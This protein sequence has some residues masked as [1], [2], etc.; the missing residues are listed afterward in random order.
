[1]SGALAEVA[2]ERARQDARWGEQN[3]PDGTGAVLHFEDADSARLVCQTRAR[4]GEVTWQHIL[5]EEYCEAMQED[6]PARLR[7]ELL[8][9]AAV[10]VN[11]IEAI[12]RR[13]VDAEDVLDGP[14]WVCA[15]C[16]I[17]TESEPCFEHQPEAHALSI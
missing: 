5:A 1:M 12:D 15:V 17:P 4:D 2:A 13:T 11:W 10:A 16:G 9:V 3:H 8:Q 14:V 6:E 7:S